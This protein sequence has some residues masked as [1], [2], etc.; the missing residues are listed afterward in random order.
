MRT[1]GLAE[2]ERAIYPIEWIAMPG[3]ALLQRVSDGPRRGL[4]PGRPLR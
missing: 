1:I 4:E 2:F 3:A